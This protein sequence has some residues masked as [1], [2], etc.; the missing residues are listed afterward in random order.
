MT[1]NKEKYRESFSSEIDTAAPL[2]ERA[3]EAKGGRP[4]RG[5]GA[6]DRGPHSRY[7]YCVNK[8]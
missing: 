2:K 7:A 8:Q 6:I 4:P 1:R 3:H 5:P